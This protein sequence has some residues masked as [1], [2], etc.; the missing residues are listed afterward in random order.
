MKPVTILKK[1]TLLLVITSFFLNGCFKD[2]ITKTYTIYRPVYKSKAEVRASIKSSA[3]V[4]VEN[5]GKLFVVG[6]YI[7]L[8]EINKGIH[9][10]DN[11]NPAAPVNKYFINI[12]GNVDLAV[13]GNTLYADMYTD[14]VTLD[15]SNPSS[16][17][18]SKTEQGIFPSRSYQ[19]G[20]FADTSRFITEWIKK[21]TT[22]DGNP[23][24]YYGGIMYSYLSSMD[25]QRA[26]LSSASPTVGISGSMAR[27]TLLGNYLYTVSDMALN[28]F[29][30]VQP[31]DPTLVSKITL[32]MN[33]ET[34]YPFKNNLFIGSQAGMLIYSTTNP[35]Q[36][37]RLANFIHATACDP[38]IADDN[39]A[40]VTLHSQTACRGITS[41]VNQLDIVNITNLSSP[42]MVKSY[43]LTNPHGL[44]KDGN[45]LFVCDGAAGLKVFDVTDI[46]KLQLLQTLTGLDA[47]DIITVNKVAIVVA[48]DGLYQYDYSDMRNIKFLSRV[49]YN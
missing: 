29:N 28:V 27:F 18:I 37:A 22:I 44:S 20:F 4:A 41:T 17:Q 9:V 21:D 2:T 8:N 32:G 49:S 47:Y 30:V 12:P 43:A 10:I 35:A 40:Y 16:I 48:K 23:P 6:N 38:V 13:T 42:F 14:L 39:Y 24:M 36:P 19:G 45:T 34:I 5:P 26:M 25:M 7:F 11:T 3:P 46:Y 15:L 1:I 33:I 31:Q